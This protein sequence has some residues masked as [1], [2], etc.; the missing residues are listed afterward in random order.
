ME[1][2]ESLGRLEGVRLEDKGLKGDGGKQLC[3]F[4]KEKGIQYVDGKA[5]C[6]REEGGY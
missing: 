2:G 3:F 4:R 6:G 5:S 1:E